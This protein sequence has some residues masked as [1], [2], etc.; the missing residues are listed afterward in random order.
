MAR[1]SVF[2]LYN[3]LAC[4]RPHNYVIEKPKNM[5]ILY[6]VTSFG[7]T[8]IADETGVFIGW[9]SI[10]CYSLQSIFDNEVHAV[11]KIKGL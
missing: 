4:V 2:D 7:K 5:A 6:R 9:D 11:D 1:Y 10:D 8:K 3:K